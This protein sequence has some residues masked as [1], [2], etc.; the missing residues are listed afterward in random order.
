MTPE[1][2]IQGLIEA[3]NK[4]VEERRARDARIA[5]LEAENRR[6]RDA[7]IFFRDLGCPLCSGDCAS[8]NPPVALCP[9]REAHE[10][11]GPA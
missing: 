11:L 3:G 8:A 9:M 2:R 10:A 7:L 5:E 4:L 6:L 1:A